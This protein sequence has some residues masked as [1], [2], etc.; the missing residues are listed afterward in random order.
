MELEPT[1]PRCRGMDLIPRLLLVMLGAVLLAGAFF[2]LGGA[3]TGE[4]RSRRI[5]DTDADGEPDET[6]SQK[7][8]SLDGLDLK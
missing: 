3:F 2:A 1:E 5:T 7:A 6:P 8:R 4:A